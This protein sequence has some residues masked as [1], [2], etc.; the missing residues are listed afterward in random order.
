MYNNYDVSFL[1]FL[2]LFAFDGPSDLS[3]LGYM[4]LNSGIKFTV[5]S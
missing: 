2:A 5:F 1:L 3:I 4:S